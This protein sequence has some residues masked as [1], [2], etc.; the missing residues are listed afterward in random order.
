MR[1]NRAPVLFTAH[2]VDDFSRIINHLVS[3]SRLFYRK[4]TNRLFFRITYWAL[5]KVLAFNPILRYYFNDP[6][7]YILDHQPPFHYN[8]IL[9]LILDRI[10]WLRTPVSISVFHNV[11]F[12]DRLHSWTILT[13][14]VVP[15]LLLWLR[16]HVRVQRFEYFVHFVFYSPFVDLSIFY[17]STNVTQWFPIEHGWFNFV[18][19]SYS[20]SV[21]HIT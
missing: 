5:T 18:G 14:P 6:V 20:K 8:H 9:V 11:L 16:Y 19:F 7:I 13:P 10:F 21:R 12:P 1:S 15:W 4:K 2:S 17:S 3:T